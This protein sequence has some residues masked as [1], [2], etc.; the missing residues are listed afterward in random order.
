MRRRLPVFLRAPE[1]EALLAAAT[2]ARDACRSATKWLAAERNRLII[3]AG[4]LLGARV[5][6]LCGLRVED[7]D[8]EQGLVLI[9]HGKGDKDRALPVPAK[10]LV[11]LRQWVGRQ[12]TGWLFP[13]PKG[14]RLSPRTVQIAVKRLAAAAGILKRVTPHKLRHSYASRLVEKGVDIVAVR[15]LMGHSSVAVTSI[16]LHADPSRLRAAVDKL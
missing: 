2:A 5:S 1:A 10:L 7:V 8:L 9:L 15:D 14:R 16:Y 4:L 6:E 12:R 13:G 3:L 11:E